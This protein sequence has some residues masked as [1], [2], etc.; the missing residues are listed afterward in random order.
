MK[1]LKL[2]L[3]F[4]LCAFTATAQVT[5]SYFENK[6]AFESFPLLKQSM[7]QSFPT[8]QMP[9]VDVEKLLREDIYLAGLNLPFRFGH[10]FDV[11]Y[12]MKDGVW[13]CN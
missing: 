1:N 13:A 11:D 9:E 4:L 6:D 7:F 5:T 12:S 8:I 10:G 2:L 3:V